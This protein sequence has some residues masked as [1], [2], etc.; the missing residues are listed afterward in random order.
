MN[1][2]LLNQPTNENGCP[3]CG[4]GNV[5]SVSYTWWGGVIGPRIFHHTKCKGCGYTYNSKTRKSN[6]T[7]ILLFSLIGVV[8]GLALVFLFRSMR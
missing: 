7:N 1:P 4:S 6:N 3:Q 2:E 8:V 5:D